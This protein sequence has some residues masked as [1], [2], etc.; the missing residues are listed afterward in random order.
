MTYIDMPPDASALYSLE[1]PASG[2]DTWFMDMYQAYE[3]LPETM[4]AAPGGP[5]LQAR[6]HPF[7][8]RASL[9]QGFEETY[10][11][12]GTA[13]RRAP[14]GDPPSRKAAARPSIPAAV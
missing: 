3:A 4:K 7:Q 9:R 12:R 5:D 10:T 14:A 2:G 13:R 8:R 11:P 6:R 1:I